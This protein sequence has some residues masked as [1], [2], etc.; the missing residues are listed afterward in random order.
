[1]HLKPS[2]AARCFQELSDNRTFRVNESNLLATLWVSLQFFFFTPHNKKTP[3]QPLNLVIMAIQE[4]DYG[5]VQFREEKEIR[6]LTKKHL[7]HLTSQ[8]FT[9]S[10]P[11]SDSLLCHECAHIVRRKRLRTET[12]WLPLL[13]QGTWHLSVERSPKS[14][15]HM[16]SVGRLLFSCSAVTHLGR[17]PA[18]SNGQRIRPSG[19][20][21]ALSSKCM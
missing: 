4:S 10:P 9:T 19:N 1:M 8:T 18:L 6:E 20:N 21:L 5:V 17:F 16:G 11:I 3:K 15:E 12:F 14:V 7:H 2:R 13:V